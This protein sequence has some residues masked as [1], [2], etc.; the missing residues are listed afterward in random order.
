MEQLSSKTTGGIEFVIR[1]YTS[2]D[3]NAIMELFDN[4]LVDPSLSYATD[5]NGAISSL[6]PVI[7]PDENSIVAISADG[8]L[9]YCQ[10]VKDSRPQYTHVGHLKIFFSSQTHGVGVGGPMLQKTIELASGMGLRRLEIKVNAERKGARALYRKIG[11]TEE[12]TLLGSYL[13]PDGSLHDEVILGLI[14]ETTSN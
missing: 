3:E 8:V 10:I 12:G 14:P 7:P 9:G 4:L 2:T 11:F 5:R 6:Q 13:A 1:A